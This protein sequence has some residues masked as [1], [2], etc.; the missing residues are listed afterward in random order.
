MHVDVPK[1]PMESMKDVA[2]HYLMIVL[3][4]LTALGLEAWIEHA[5]HQ[6]AAEAASTQIEAEIH[7]NRQAVQHALDNDRAREAVLKKIRDGLI[8]DIKS[9]ATDAVIMQHLQQEA[10]DGVYLDWRWP[11]LNHTAW[12]VAIA[13]QSAGWI[14]SDKLHRYATVYSAQDAHAALMHT[15][16]PLVID[17]PR[18]N[19]VLLQLQMGQVQPKELLLSVNQMWEIANESSQNLTVLAQLMDGTLTGPGSAH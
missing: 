6:H 16:M 8:A 14:D 12:E 17:G 2:K 1:L 9:N 18:M 3:G 13:N 4:I 19:D 15:D 11:S 10:P 7:E 5:H